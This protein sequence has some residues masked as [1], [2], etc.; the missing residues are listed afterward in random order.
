MT[1][2][3]VSLWLMA[4]VLLLMLLSIVFGLVHIAVMMA[5]QQEF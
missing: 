5:K 4:A 2:L 1:L 3:D